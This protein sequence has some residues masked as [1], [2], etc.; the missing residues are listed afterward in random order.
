M[1]K[2][3]HSSN[4]VQLED[5]NKIDLTFKNKVFEQ[6]GNDIYIG[7]TK[8]TEQMRAL[9]KDQAQIFLTSNL[10][11]ILDATITEEAID[12]ALRQS[13]NYEHVL[14]AKMLHHWNHVMKN[15]INALAK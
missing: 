7:G 13:T 11:E 4:Q 1:N 6:R 15:L 12:L 8:V 5:F 9:L 14:T 3:H 2:S 10:Y